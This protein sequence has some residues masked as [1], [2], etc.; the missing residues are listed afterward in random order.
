MC[1]V[2]GLTAF[3]AHAGAQG[4]DIPTFSP[5]AIFDIFENSA[6]L[7]ISKTKRGIKVSTRII[8][9]ASG[10]RKITIVKIRSKF[11]ILRK[12][13]AKAKR[14]FQNLSNNVLTAA[15]AGSN[16]SEAAARRVARL[17]VRIFK[18]GI[19]VAKLEVRLLK[20]LKDKTAEEIESAQQELDSILNAQEVQ[21]QELDQILTELP[22]Q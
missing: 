6:K 3:T 17:G 13:L 11:K 14:Q 15:Y 10:K 5:T 19:K 16:I 8:K 12:R 1:F 7:G 22:T 4:L 9:R 18:L 21:L 20:L 2:F